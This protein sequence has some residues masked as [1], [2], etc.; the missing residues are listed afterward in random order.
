LRH[1]EKQQFEI[2][3]L[4]AERNHNERRMSPKAQAEA[5]AV[6]EGAAFHVASVP[7]MPI[8]PRRRSP[9]VEDKE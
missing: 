3:E 6:N 7:V 8:P 2:A 9:V 5:E 1:F 4:A